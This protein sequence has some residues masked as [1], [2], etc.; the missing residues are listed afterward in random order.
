MDVQQLLFFSV[1]ACVYPPAPPPGYIPASLTGGFKKSPGKVMLA[2]PPH[3][4]S[5][6][7]SQEPFRLGFSMRKLQVSWS[8]LKTGIGWKGRRIGSCCGPGWLQA[9]EKAKG[10][11]CP[12]APA[13]IS[14]PLN[15]ASRLS[16]PGPCIICR[17]NCWEHFFYIGN[18]KT[19]ITLCVKNVQRNL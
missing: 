6:V 9:F 17:K 10:K 5:I 8:I 1:N 12:L 7:D 13:H 2:W 15:W 14:L 16:H 11:P 19:I 4:Q 18:F 3:L